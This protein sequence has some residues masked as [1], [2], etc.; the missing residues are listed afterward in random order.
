MTIISSEKLPLELVRYYA[1]EIIS[2]LEYMHARRIVH[3]DL[4]PENILLDSN[5]HLLVVSVL[6][7]SILYTTADGLWRQQTT[8]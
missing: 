4:K 1:A 7:N 2:A 5:C 6:L 3:R 8:D